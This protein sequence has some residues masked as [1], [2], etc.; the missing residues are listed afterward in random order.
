MAIRTRPT[1]DPS[2]WSVSEMFKDGASIDMAVNGSV[3]P[4]DFKVTAAFRMR[5]SSMHFEIL[6]VAT[7]PGLFGGLAALANGVAVTIHDE[8]DVQLF[9]LT[10]DETVKQ[11][12]DWG[13]LAGL[14]E[15]ESVIDSAGAKPDMWNINVGLVELNLILEPGWYVQVKIQDNLSLIDHFHGGIHGRLV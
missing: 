4:V 6:D 1:R 11:N 5:L 9:D 7:D 10:E 13:T 14:S 8:N 15:T 12:A 3:T 2:E